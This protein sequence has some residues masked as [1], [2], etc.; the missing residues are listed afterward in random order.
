MR[1]IKEAT[2]TN[3][4]GEGQ[5]SAETEITVRLSSLAANTEFS[6]RRLQSLRNPFLPFSYK[7]DGEEIRFLFDVSG[8]KSFLSIRGEAMP[9]RL[10]ILA[11]AAGLIGLSGIS[12]S[13]HPKN[14]YYDLQNRCHVMFRDLQSPGSG[15][16]KEVEKGRL[17]QFKALAGAC[18]QEKL[19]FED[20]EQGGM[21]LLNKHPTLKKLA[22]AETFME[23]QKILEEEAERIDA[24]NKR[25]KVL[26]SRRKLLGLKIGTAFLGAMTLS[27]LGLGAYHVYYER[28]YQKASVQAMDA[29][30]RKDYVGVVDALRP[31]LTQRLTTTQKYILATSYV[32]GES[33]SEQQKSNILARM[34]MA[35]NVKVLEYWVE[36]GRLNVTEAENLAMQM[37]DDQLLLFAYLKEKYL[38]ELNEDMKGEEKAAAL[39]QVQKNI[40]KLSEELGLLPD[41]EKDSTAIKDGADSV[42]MPSKQQETGGSEAEQE[43]HAQDGET[44]MGSPLGESGE[45]TANPDVLPTLELR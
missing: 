16:E 10:A 42:E 45:K 37:S 25:N 1:E 34:D 26:F 29:F 24:D 35:G 12:F 23:A 27:L 7:Q 9:R 38:L 15:A 32:K 4:F 36:L 41:A 8:K 5:E 30:V 3:G 44:A 18:L 17:L 21:D 39:E 11:D 19:G 14:L 6:L 28:P 20:Y 31:F 2:K 43:S 22:K 13:M 40:G 33:L